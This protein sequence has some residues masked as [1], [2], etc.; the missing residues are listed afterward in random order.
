M[1]RGCVEEAQCLILLLR[2]QALRGADFLVVFRHAREVCFCIIDS[3]GARRLLW[4]LRGLGP[5]RGDGGV[6][7]DGR[8]GEELSGAKCR[9]VAEIGGGEAGA[10]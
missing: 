3:D 5:F 4:C 9:G 10:R 2:R 8:S 1:D 6:I 7:G